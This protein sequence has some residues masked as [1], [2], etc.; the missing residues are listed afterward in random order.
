MGHMLRPAIPRDK[1][2]VEP[3]LEIRIPGM[4]DKEILCCAHHTRLVFGMDGSGSGIMG[5]A[6]L[7][8]DDGQGAAPAHDEIN[9]PHR[10][11]IAHTK[12]AVALE[13][14]PRG[15]HIFRA[16]APAMIALPSR[17]VHDAPL[18]CN[19]RA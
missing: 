11:F 2:R 12:Q 15:R 7:H 5:W 16:Q 4:A 14:Q 18:S 17:A 13:A 1:H 19:A 8:L 6:R 3:N 10:G 9:F